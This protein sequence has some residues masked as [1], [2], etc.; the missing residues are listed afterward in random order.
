MDVDNDGTSNQ[1]HTH[2]SSSPPF[3]PSLS[4]TFSVP[5][6]Q[7][8]VWVGAENQNKDQ[9]PTDILESQRQ[10]QCTQN[11]PNRMR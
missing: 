3:S 9:K 1:N 10:Q 7:C 11:K 5:R 8:S 2:S 6:M 4:Q